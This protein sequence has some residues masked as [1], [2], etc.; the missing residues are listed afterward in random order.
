MKIKY[1]NSEIKDKYIV[2]DFLV[3]NA[4]VEDYDITFWYESVVNEYTLKML[5]SSDLSGDFVPAQ[6]SAI[7]T[8]KYALDDLQYCG[9]EK[10]NMIQFLI[11]DAE[12]SE[13]DAVEVSFENL[14]IDI[15]ITEITK[16]SVNGRI[17]GILSEGE[18]SKNIDISYVG[19]GVTDSQVCLKFIAENNSKDYY[20]FTYWYASQVNRCA[21]DMSSSSEISGALD[22]K[23]KVL[24]SIKYNL[25]MLKKA[26]IEVIDEMSFLF[27]KKGEDKGKASTAKFTGLNI[28]II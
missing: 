15:P 16:K 1:T 26:Q 7:L 21:V 22:A 25:E 18:M 6:G 20:G 28:P 5:T 12:T 8:I 19:Y 10:V 2:L 23:G 9:I 27:D 17:K 3:E 14:K 4:S 11:G 13:D 24:L